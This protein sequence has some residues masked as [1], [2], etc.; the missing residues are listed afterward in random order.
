MGDVRACGW[1]SGLKLWWVVLWCLGVAG[2]PGHDKRRLFFA[3][4]GVA[5]ECE[6]NLC[7]SGVCSKSC[8]TSSECGKGVCLANAC[9]PLGKVACSADNTCDD[10][11]QGRPCQVGRCV[12]GSCSAEPAADGSACGVTTSCEAFACSAG[13][14]ASAAGSRN[15]D[16]ANPCTTDTCVPGSGCSHQVAAGTPCDDGVACTASDTCT[17]S[18]QCAG[19]LLRWAVS[20]GQ[21]SS[22]AAIA[23]ADGQVYLLAAHAT[24]AS[25]S[26]QLH[27]LAGNDGT[28]QWT[29]PVAQLPGSTPH[30]LVTDGSYVVASWRDGQGTSA[31]AQLGRWADNGTPD[32]PVQLASGVVIRGLALHEDTLWAV[33]DAPGLVGTKAHIERRN[34]ETLAEA[35]QVSGLGVFVSEQLHAAVVAPGGLLLAVGQVQQTAASSGD[36]WLVRVDATGKLL[37][38]DTFANPDGADTLYAIAPM[39]LSGGADGFVAAGVR[40]TSAGER[41]WLLRLTASGALLWERT[42][43]DLP[44][45]ARPM[46]VRSVVPLDGAMALL[47]HY[48]DAQ[49]GQLALLTDAFGTLTAARTVGQGQ[50][51]SAVPWSSDRWLAAGVS[52]NDATGRW[53]VHSGDQWLQTQCSARCLGTSPAECDDGQPCTTHICVED[54]CQL[55]TSPPGYPCGDGDAC[56]TQPLC[57]SSGCGNPGTR[58]CT[59]NNPCTSDDCD[60]VSGCRYTT[61][62]NTTPCEGGSCQ[63]GV[64]TP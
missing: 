41:P 37:G 20:G 17:A 48:S 55:V 54:A 8:V 44:P 56:S 2:C 6:S 34:A 36:G 11:L 29:K 63:D 12:S 38:S 16:D 5:S 10:L 19:D 23:A 28:T 49:S 18:G 59:D 43:T 60:P 32:P 64:C 45:P 9:V 52:A 26:V 25:G 1:W 24:D 15:C 27:S 39:E 21:G 58:T 35:Q 61:L 33:G 7:V 51:L 62:D 50:L 46:V 53:Q 22:G 3:S 4:C 47:G 57:T 14:C 40:T 42:L 13:S 30:A 31:T